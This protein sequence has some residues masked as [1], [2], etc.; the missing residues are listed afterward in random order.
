MGKIIKVGYGE[1]KSFGMYNNLKVSAEAEVNMNE[2]PE[3]VLME[4]KKFV[5]SQLNPE[6]THLGAD[7]TNLETKKLDLIHEIETLVETKRILNK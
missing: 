6:I 4:I 1:L 2:E 3:Q 7:I 5:Q